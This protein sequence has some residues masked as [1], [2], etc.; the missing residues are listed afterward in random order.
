[1]ERKAYWKLTFTRTHSDFLLQSFALPSRPSALGRSSRPHSPGL[2]VAGASSPS[3][4][5]EGRAECAD[6]VHAE[7]QKGEEVDYHVSEDQEYV[8]S[9]EREG[10]EHEEDEDEEELLHV[11]LGQVL[12]VGGVGPI[13]S[14]A[15]SIWPEDVIPAEVE[16]EEGREEPKSHDEATA[17][18]VE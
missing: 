6:H 3:A 11:G 4:P 8:T 10:H 2:L 15:C 9:E 1:M 5:V 7:D 13:L 17:L 18:P 16:R 12:V 14:R